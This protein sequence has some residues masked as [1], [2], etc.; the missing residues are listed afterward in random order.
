MIG[1]RL[2]GGIEVQNFATEVFI[3][4]G[5]IAPDKAGQLVAAIDIGL[6]DYTGGTAS[7]RILRGDNPVL[8]T[9]EL[10]LEELTA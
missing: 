4:R 8:M 10:V 2:A 1:A 3:R 7:G 5:E 6:V 9:F